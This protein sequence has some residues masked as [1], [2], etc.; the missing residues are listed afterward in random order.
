MPSKSKEQHNFMAAVANNAS[1]AKK[2]GVP[3]SVGQEFMQA[4]K[5]MKFKG[6]QQSRPDLQKANKPKTNHGKLTLFNK[7]GDTMASKMNPKMMAKRKPMMP[8][9]GRM[10]MDNQMMQAGTAQPG[11]PAMPMRKGGM[12]KMAKGGMAKDDMAQDKKMIKRAFAM[13]DKQ[14]HKGD[15][16]DLSKLRKGGM[17]KKMAKGG[18]TTDQMKAVGR[19]MARVNNQRSG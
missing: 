19:N 17:T 9:G 1:F 18:V 8:V 14:E 16:T 11:T 6:G 15:R 12:T 10:G 3:K 5:G 2:A 7:G 4:D 13:H